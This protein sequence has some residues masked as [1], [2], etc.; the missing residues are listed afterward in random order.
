[1]A[2]EE[3]STKVVKSMKDLSLM[4]KDMATEFSLGQMV[5]DTMGPG[6][7]EKNTARLLTLLRMARSE[8]V[9]GRVVRK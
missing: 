4:T 3:K 6:S 7:K 5:E 2:T 1:M 8:K 9:F